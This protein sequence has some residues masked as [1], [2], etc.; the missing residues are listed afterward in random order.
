MTLDD[1]ASTTFTTEIEI[2]GIDCNPSLDWV[3]PENESEVFALHQ[4]IFRLDEDLIPTECKN[5]D[6]TSPYVIQIDGNSY[7][8]DASA[9]HYFYLDE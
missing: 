1:T 3:L 5:E 9:T 2:L 8:P 7:L 6:G 4:Y